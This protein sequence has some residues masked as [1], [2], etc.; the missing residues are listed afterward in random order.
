MVRRIVGVTVGLVVIGALGF[1][2]G[3]RDEKVPS[4]H[5]TRALGRDISA[6]GIGCARLYPIRTLFLPDHDVANCE[7]GSAAV[8][9][10]VWTGVSAMTGLGEASR[11]APW[12]VGPNWMVATTNRLAAI[13]VA[14]VIGGDLIPSWLPGAP[15]PRRPTTG[16]MYVLET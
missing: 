11:H 1:A 13:Q 6:H 7:V 15:L 3:D 14:M 2:L 5:S 9:L 8:T 4:Y 12:V 10:H 16:R